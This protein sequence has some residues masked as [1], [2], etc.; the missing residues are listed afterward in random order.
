MPWVAKQQVQEKR[1][2]SVSICRSRRRV[3]LQCCKRALLAV[4]GQLAGRAASASRCRRRSTDAGTN[5]RGAIVQVGSAYRQLDRNDRSWFLFAPGS[6]VRRAVVAVTASALYKNVVMLIVISNV[7][8]LGAGDPTCDAECLK[9][10]DPKKQV[11][12]GGERAVSR[13]WRCC[14]TQLLTGAA[15]S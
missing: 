11:R 8:Y 1:D 4:G 9:Q 2:S 6:R 7:I 13:P 3:R 12:R 5:H 15:A 14:P 10:T